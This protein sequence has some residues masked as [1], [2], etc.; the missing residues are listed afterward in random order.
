M[1]TL[2][3]NATRREPANTA[4][5]LRGRPAA[6]PQGDSDAK[7]RRF[8]AALRSVT[9]PRQPATTADDKA[10]PVAE[11][12][13]A[14]EGQQGA[15]SP[16]GADGN[17]DDAQTA[18]GAAPAKVAATTDG[19]DPVVEADVAEAVPPRDVTEKDAEPDAALAAAVAGT[20]AASPPKQAEVAERPASE[21]PTDA[22]PAVAAADGIA[23][24]STATGEAK[25]D[26]APSNAPADGS[27]DAEPAPPA[28]AAKPAVVESAEPADAAPPEG[29]SADP[30]TKAMGQARLDPQQ[31]PAAAAVQ[32][33][34]PATLA[35]S[36]PAAPDEPD[37]RA[38]GA[39]EGPLRAN[40]SPAPAA[41]AATPRLVEQGVDAV[42]TAVRT[43]LV[44]G[45]QQ[46]AMTLRLDPPQLGSM[47][48]NVQ[49]VEGQL[50]ATFSAG[51]D[52]AH[53][54]L[55]QNLPQLKAGLEQAGFNV[56]RLNVQRAPA[57][58]QPQDGQFH[59]QQHQDGQPREQMQQHQRDQQRRETLTRIWRRGGFDGERTNLVA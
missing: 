29:Q 1:Q 35:P 52:V 21:P 31:L 26:I 44:G 39:I 50:T 3:N 18:E 45:K 16:D 51:S 24:P 2:M 20:A 22:T 11:K 7:A 4:A 46:H 41:P 37:A 17:G 28:K 10:A 54:L 13:S 30:T 34:R 9:T 43:N 47:R 23:P 12:P 32:A 36:D 15:A 40:S 58:Q 55:Q 38:M 19:A 25:S 56:D 57:A 33:N 6:Q 8:G 49:M 27:Q 42:V 59:Q 53:R 48:V 5:T 14:D